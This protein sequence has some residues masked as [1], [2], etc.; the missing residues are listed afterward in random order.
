MHL[1]RFPPP[2]LVPAWLS[3]LAPAYRIT[4]GA[5]TVTRRGSVPRVSIVVEKRA[6][7]KKVTRAWGLEPFLID[8]TSLTDELQKLLACSVGLD[9]RPGG[10]GTEIL[11]QG[12]HM[13]ALSKHLTKQY[14][15]PG[16]YVDATDKAGGGSKKK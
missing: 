3:R 2:Q 9:P 15:L 10:N 8:P 12:S 1:V 16:K 5:A 6:G 11:V 7:N 13:E 14:G 4:R